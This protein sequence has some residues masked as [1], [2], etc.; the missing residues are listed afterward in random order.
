MRNILKS[1]LT[2]IVV[3]S[4]ALGILSSCKQ[5][6]EY[7]D[8]TFDTDAVALSV[9]GET[10]FERDDTNT[11][12]GQSS[13]NEFYVA[14][15]ELGTWYSVSLNTLPTSEGEEVSGKVVWRLNH[16]SAS[17]KRENVTFTVRSID[18]K[19]GEIK[20]WSKTGGIWVII[21]SVL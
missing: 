13:D 21:Y 20:L 2:Y 14:S 8:P 18:S 4:L 7:P 19:T 1:A 5:T 15:D 3:A 6:K 9:E 10:I 12:K 16:D 17:C 11:Q